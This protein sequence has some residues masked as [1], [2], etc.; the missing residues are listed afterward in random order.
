[1]ILLRLSVGFLGQGDQAKWWSCAFLNPTGIRLLQR[2]FPRTAWTA[3]LRSTTDAAVRVHD[4][5]LGRIGSAHLFRLP[6]GFE[7]HLERAIDRLDGEE[8]AALVGSREGAFSHLKSLAGPLIDAP[9]GPVKIGTFSTLLTQ[10]AMR[11][12]ARHY[13]SAFGKGIRCFPYFTPEAA[14]GP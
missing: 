6:P 11:E 12:L 14:D 8:A 2:V 7:D 10:E 1:M 13:H 4:K 9:E 5:A 3:A